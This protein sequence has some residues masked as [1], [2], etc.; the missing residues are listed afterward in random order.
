MPASYLGSGWEFP[1]AL[2]KEGKIARSSDEAKI[3]ESIG[4]ILRTT[5]GERVMRPD[6]GSS[7]QELVFAVNDS[8]TAGRVAATVRQALI[9]WEPR[10]DVLDVVVTPD[11]AEPEVLPV[12]VMYR[13]RATNT[14]F[15]LVYPSYLG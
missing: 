12:R 13:V 8:T 6:F 15:N 14:V 11:P 4:L 5:R 2:T 9:L 3:H 1:V 10:I 7:L